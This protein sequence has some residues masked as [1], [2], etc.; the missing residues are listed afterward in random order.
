MATSRSEQEMTVGILMSVAWKEACAKMEGVSIHPDPTDVNVMT[1][2]NPL[3]TFPS[4]LVS[5]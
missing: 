1:D 5:F 4:A 3:P 2:L